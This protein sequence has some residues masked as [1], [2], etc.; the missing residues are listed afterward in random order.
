MPCPFSGFTAGDGAGAG[1]DGD[2]ECAA[3]VGAGADA[4]AGGA[5]VGAGASAFEG[6]GGGGG[7]S[8]AGSV[9]TADEWPFASA[10][11][12]CTALEL[13]MQLEV[14][15]TNLYGMGTAETTLLSRMAFTIL[16]STPVGLPLHRLLLVKVPSAMRS[17]REL[18]P[19]PV[20]PSKSTLTKQPFFQ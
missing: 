7:G 1:A 5:V 14:L 20:L 13:R 18:F 12:T 16:K 19:T 11:G 10:A 6:D 15:S 17:S 4:G 8:S 3:N 9:S 2:S